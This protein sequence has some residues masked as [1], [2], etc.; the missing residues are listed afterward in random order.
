MLEYTS[1][2]VIQ[3]QKQYDM[4][5]ASL[6]YCNEL[7][8]NDVYIELNKIEKK[9]LDSTNEIYEE[10]Y[11]KLSSKTS[12]LIDEEKEKL[13]NLI[14]LVED[15]IK[16]LNNRKEKHHKITDTVVEQPRVLGELE[17]N[18]YKRKLGII[19]KYKQNIKLKKELKREVTILEEK[20]KVCSLKLKSNEKINSELEEKMQDIL[21]KSFKAMDL[22]S[23]LERK[24]EIE[25]AYKEL[26]FAKEKAIENMELARK[27][28]NSALIT[29]C[30]KMLDSITAE[31]NKYFEKKMLLELL[32]IYDDKVEQYDELIAKREKMQDIFRNIE[33]SDFYKLVY[34]DMNKQYNTI[35][36]EEQDYKMYHEIISDLKARKEKIDKI[37]A[38]ND[39]QEFKGILDE[40][41]KNE[42]IRQEQLLQEQRKREY[43]ERQR[44]LI[45][46]NKRQEELKRRQK[47]IE[48]EK[49]RE[50]KRKQEELA[51]KE[52]EQ[53]RKREEQID[54]ILEES[55]INTKEDNNISV[56]TIE[57]K[58]KTIHVPKEIVFDDEK[59]EAK[60][61]NIEENKIE[62]NTNRNSLFESIYDEMKKRM[63]I[64]KEENNSKHQDAEETKYYSDSVVNKDKNDFSAIPVIKNEN[65]VAKKVKDEVIEFEDKKLNEE[66]NIFVDD[67]VFPNI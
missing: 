9:I 47:L 66:D 58:S 10:A 50:E 6:E 27:N 67:I 44:R 61:E 48:E 33:N 56:S 36:I 24:E 2:E 3:A 8:K 46:E 49:E 23:L 52:K 7:D 15:R 35:K 53:Q 45:L 30:K 32:N 55:E 57:S 38:E 54:S 17:L 37:D 25:L 22:Y 11:N 41:I 28:S 18:D 19:N 60:E 16:Y 51:L 40:L 20:E 59:I 64:E 4:L 42:K 43:E 63:E 62:S 39:S 31:Y 5:L 13:S 14:K 29:E 65:L 26:S 21:V 12:T 1:R 34:F